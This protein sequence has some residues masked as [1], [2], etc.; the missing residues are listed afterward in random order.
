MTTEETLQKWSTHW[1]FTRA[2]KELVQAAQ[3]AEKELRKPD[4]APY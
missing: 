1:P 2:S 4:E 3:K